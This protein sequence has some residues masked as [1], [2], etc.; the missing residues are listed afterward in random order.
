MAFGA[1]VILFA[2]PAL[3]LMLHVSSYNSAKPFA[4]PTR[5]RSLAEQLRAERNEDM[6]FF[7]ELAQVQRELFSLQLARPLPNDPANAEFVRE[8]QALESALRE[9]E[10]QFPR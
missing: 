1:T 2:I 5:N 7:S 4:E 9:I 8:V 10:M 6:Q 3:L